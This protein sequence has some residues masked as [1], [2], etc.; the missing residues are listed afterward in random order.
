MKLCFFRLFEATSIISRFLKGKEPSNM[1]QEFC[2]GYTSLPPMH[3]MVLVAD[4]AFT[5][6]LKEMEHLRKC[7]HCML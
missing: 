4:F 5:Y 7:S 3:G 2:Q 6:F 1:D